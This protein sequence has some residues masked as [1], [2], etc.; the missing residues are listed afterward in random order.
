MES[1][2]KYD[3]ERFIRT[4]RRQGIRDEAVL[5]AMA[6][7]PREKFVGIN[8]LEF[9]YD[10]SPLPIEEGQTISQPFI[11]ALMTEALML[12]P[13]DRVLEVGTGSGYAAAVLAEVAEEVYTIERHESLAHQ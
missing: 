9:A 2:I 4:L 13:A 1:L 6:S 5:K 10:D 7:V 3:K 11:V 8:L 12:K